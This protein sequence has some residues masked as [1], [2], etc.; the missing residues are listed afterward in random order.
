MG[1]R[2]TY[3]RVHVLDRATDLFWQRGFHA[4]SVRELA[5][6]MGINIY[7]LYAEFGSKE[8]LYEA[9]LQR[10][11]DTVVSGHFGRL[12]SAEAG[13][14]AV[15]DVAH[16]FGDAA[17][18]GNPLLGCLMCNA[19][20]E[21]APTDVRSREVGASYSRRI[22]SAFENAL[23]NAVAVG[24]LRADAPVSPLAHFLTVALLGV[25]VALRGG[26]DPE[27]MRDAANQA[28]ARVESFV[29]A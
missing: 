22:T 11:D 17:V 28:L 6:A 2:K 1:R 8:A 4:T 15:R 26:A 25:F 16:F 29:A 13:L 14:R 12:E 21:Q 7:S 19:I 24:E 10:Y 9:A 23:G 3:D 18:G 27:L 20:T 5:D